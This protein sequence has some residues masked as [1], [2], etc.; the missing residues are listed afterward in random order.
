LAELGF[1]K[2]DNQ[3]LDIQ[4]ISHR[5][6]RIRA[7]TRVKRPETAKTKTPKSPKQIEN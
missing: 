4:E 5:M 7:R 1:R 6:K 2:L 3:T